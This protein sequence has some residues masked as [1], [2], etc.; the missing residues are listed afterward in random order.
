MIEKLLFLFVFLF[1][2]FLGI[3]TTFPEGGGVNEN[4]LKASMY[5]IFAGFFLVMSIFLIAILIIKSL[6]KK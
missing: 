3:S 6:S 2:L 4:T 1:L 5:L